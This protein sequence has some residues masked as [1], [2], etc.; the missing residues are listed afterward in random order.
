M[1]DNVR[2]IFCNSKAGTGKTTQAVGCANILVH[3]GKFEKMEY[4]F[5]TP[6]EDKMGFR[7]GDQ[8]EKEMAYLRPQYDALYEIN[9]IPEKV[10]EEIACAECIKAG[11]TW[12]SAHSINFMRGGNLAGELIILDEA[13]NVSRE[14]LKM[15][16]TRVHDTSKIIVIGHDGQ[17]DIPKGRSGFVPYQEWFKPEPYCRVVNLTQNFRGMISQH[18]DDFMG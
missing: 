16:L 4:M 2:V 6:F 17:V 12:V 14:E 7:P 11:K 1:D 8:Q 3:S 10:I 5:A 13:Q 18:A 15:V 9:E